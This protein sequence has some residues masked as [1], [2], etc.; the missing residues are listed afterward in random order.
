MARLVRRHHPY[1]DALRSVRQLAIGGT[2]VAGVSESGFPGGVIGV[3]ERALGLGAVLVRS[4]VSVAVAGELPAGLVARSSPFPAAGRAGNEGLGSCQGPQ[5]HPEV[6]HLRAL[7]PNRYQDIGV[8]Q[9][10]RAT[11]EVTHPI[12]GTQPGEKD[13][14]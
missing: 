12:R 13:G 14:L 1:G 11:T 10:D 6:A 2:V 8:A 3:D 5:Q 4:S 9:S 7:A